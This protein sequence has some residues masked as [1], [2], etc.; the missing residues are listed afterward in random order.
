MSLKSQLSHLMSVADACGILGEDRVSRIVSSVL[1]L[2]HRNQL[3]ANKSMFTKQQEEVLEEVLADETS[4]LVHSMLYTTNAVKPNNKTDADSQAVLL[5]QAMQIKP[6]TNSTDSSLM[7]SPSHEEHIPPPIKACWRKFNSR[8]LLLDKVTLIKFLVPSSAQPHS[9]PGGHMGLFDCLTY[10]LQSKP[11]SASPSSATSGGLTPP[12]L[13]SIPDICIFLAICHQYWWLHTQDDPEMIVSFDKD[14]PIITTMA[15]WMFLVYDSYQKRGM[16]TRDTIH[17][18]M[19]DVYGEDTYRQS[20]MIDVLNRVFRNPNVPLTSREFVRA[21]VETMSYEPLPSHFLLD[22]M[23]AFSKA[24]MPPDN[25]STSVSLPESA[26]V[27]LQTMDRQRRWLPSICDQYHLAENRLYEIKRRFH[28]LVESSTTVIQ[29][30]PMGDTAE[31]SGNASGT[32]GNGSGS[33]TSSLGLGS[34]NGINPHFPKHVIPAAVFYQKVCYPSDELGH[35]GY[36]THPIA[37]RV[38]QSIAKLASATPVDDVGPEEEEDDFENARSYW[39]LAHVLQYGGMCV[40]SDDDDEAL[41]KWILQLFCKRGETSLNRKQVEDLLMCLCEHKDFRNSSDRPRWEINQDDTEAV[42]D[43]EEDMDDNRGS[44]SVNLRTALEL[45][46][47]PE[48]YGQTEAQTPKVPIKSLVDHMFKTVKSTDDTLTKDQLLLW[49]RNTKQYDQHRLG[50]LIMELR[51]IAGVLF[52]VPPKHA[53]MEKRLIIEIQE[54]H[55]R[56]YPQTDVSR[57]GPRGTVWYIIDDKWFRTWSEVIQKLSR[58]SED[59]DDLR[60]KAND[61]ACPRRVTQISNRSLLRDNG[62]LALRADIKWRQD[63]EILPPLAWSALQAWYDGGP[64]I[65]R[66]VVP[67]MSNTLGRRGAT[68]LRTENE[69]ELYPFF[70]TMF[71][72]DSAS[73]G[74]A[75]PFQQQVPVSRYSPVRVLLVQLCKGLDIDP[76]KGRLWLMDV[77]DS[78]HSGNNHWLLNLDSN[79]LEQKKSRNVVDGTG[80]DN[81][82]LLLELKDEE[83]GLWPR[84]VDGHDWT[85]KKDDFNGIDVG[86]GVVGLYNM[87]NTCYLNSSIQCLSHTPIFKD[88]FT[89]KCYLNDINTTNPMGHGGHLAQ[90]TAVLINN[91]WKRFNQQALHQPKRVI[92]P[93]SYAPVNAPA[94]T[95]KTFKESIGKFDERFAGNEQHDAQELLTFLLDGLGEEFNRIQEKPY[96][97][98]PDSDGRPD[99]ELAD[100]WWSNLLKRE[101]SI[102]IAMFHGQYKSLLRCKAC[103]YES[104]RFENFSCLTL[105]LPEDDNIPVTLI[106]YPCRPD[107]EIMRYSV[108]VHNNGTLY[109]VLISL[110]KVLHADEQAEKVGSASSPSDGNL[111]EPESDQEKARL[112]EVYKKMSRDMAVVDMRDNYIFKIAPNAWRLPDLQNKDTGELPAIHVVGLDPIPDELGTMN[113][114]EDALDEHQ[115]VQIDFLA[116]A[117]RRSELV[118]KDLLHPLTH[119]VFGTPLLLRIANLDGKSNKEVYDF[120][121]KHLPPYVPQGAHKFLESSESVHEDNSEKETVLVKLEEGEGEES[122]A[123]RRLNL[124]KTLSDAEDVSAGPVPRYGFRLRITSRDGRRCGQCAWYDCCIGCEVPDDNNPT[125]LSNGD[126]L[127]IDWHFAVDVATSGFGTRTTQDPLSIGGVSRGRIAGVPIKNHASCANDPKKKGHAAAITLEDCLDEFAKEEKMPEVYCSKCKDYK[128]QTKRMSLWRLPPVVIIHLKRFQFTQHMRRKLRDFVDFPLEGLDLSRIMARDVGAASPKMVELSS[129]KTENGKSPSTDENNRN[130]SPPNAVMNGDGEEMGGTEESC[131]QM[132]DDDGRSEMLYDLYGVVHHQGALSTGHYVASLKS[133]VDGQWR[134]FN[135][136]QIYEIHPRD[137]V[138]SSAYLLFYIR[139]DVAGQKLSDFW[140]V[141]KRDGVGM[142]EEEMDSLIKGRSERCV[143]S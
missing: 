96:I 19:A 69:I 4:A 91:I 12:P 121:A 42:E 104:A 81:M 1:R 112:Q 22:W 119:R 122:K 111:Q 67:N 25:T 128:M 90:V 97:E 86:D 13:V 24:M 80:T 43:G 118:S 71:L 52:G 51:L 139:R 74:E 116:L 62:S 72:C 70:V 92:A 15:Q 76:D 85:F 45:R 84:G 115:A 28:S 137:V 61:N 33:S 99:S 124:P 9:G 21:I 133:E 11:S 46:L 134:L 107:S 101:M 55:L 30:D 7:A 143:I 32:S 109:D 64:P 20:P 65:Q 29:G 53:S 31:A 105:P 58:T 47:L 142:T 135:D 38:F 56:R 129:K 59:G 89:S 140:D 44:R 37:Q 103:K 120:V 14:N 3:N 77:A 125:V 16:I 40:R 106:Y 17:R 126:S 87:G 110:A 127:A 78:E 63:Y 130:E 98:H 100:I 49:H 88:Y 26:S 141:S 6:T 68:T 57:R 10:A 60:D 117:Q 123:E 39:D 18:F 93:Q 36:L 2:Q 34:S 48:F 114:D 108:K 41:V 73:R 8:S 5:Q 132:N 54:R 82:H 94:L 113:E 79:I 66:V 102:I 131:P 95:P 138:D 136:A 35:G 50:P 83:T 23:A 27:F 75:R